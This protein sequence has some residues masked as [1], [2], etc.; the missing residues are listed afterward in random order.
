MGE[1]SL[2]YST[3]SCVICFSVPCSAVSIYI[4]IYYHLSHSVKTIINKSS[5]TMLYLVSQDT[6]IIFFPEK[7]SLWKWPTTPGGK[8][9]VCS[10]SLDLTDVITV[11]YQPR[12]R[13]N[14]NQAAIVWPEILL[15]LYVKILDTGKKRVEFILYMIKKIT[16][17]VQF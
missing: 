10:S 12:K 1:I 16:F 2:L 13:A 6:Q 4:Y 11:A 5:P 15:L 14:L 8:I 17:G 9:R 3:M 7:T